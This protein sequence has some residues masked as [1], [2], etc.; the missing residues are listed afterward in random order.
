[1]KKKLPLIIKHN[2]PVYY[3]P[4]L[5][6]FHVVHGRTNKSIIISDCT[7]F[8]N[9]AYTTTCKYLLPKQILK[10]MIRINKRKLSTYSFISLN[11]TKFSKSVC[12][13]DKSNL[14]LT[15]ILFYHKHKINLQ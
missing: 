14:S 1:M 2:C 3:N 13:T 5:H 9:D 8:Y 15:H 12:V 7:E 10:N 6:G 11:G 4:E